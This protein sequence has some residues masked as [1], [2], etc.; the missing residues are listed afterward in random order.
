MDLPTFL[1]SPTH[2]SSKLLVPISFKSINYLCFPPSHVY[3]QIGSTNCKTMLRS[4]YLPHQY[5]P[6]FPYRPLLEALISLLDTCIRC[7][8]RTVFFSHICTM[9]SKTQPWYPNGTLNLYHRQQ[10]LITRS[11]FQKFA[12]FLSRSNSVAEEWFDLSR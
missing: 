7:K 3:P 5:H 2:W 1:L 11:E 4:V 6:L 8:V 12:S 10:V 9:H